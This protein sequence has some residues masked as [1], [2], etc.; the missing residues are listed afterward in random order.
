M[1]KIL[2]K[3][4]LT[5]EERLDLINLTKKGKHS[6]RKVIHALILLNADEGEFAEV[7]KQ[8]NKSIATFLNVGESMVERVK[9]RFVEDSLEAALEDKPSTREY[10]RKID[11]DLEA[12][13]IALSCSEPPEGFVRWSLRM[14]AN[15]AIELQYFDGLSPETIRQ[16][17]KKTK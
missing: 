5:N 2:Y 4:T 12:R 16:T 1:G 14:L 11:G 10:A 3:V 9:R 17:L 8:T 6:S 15:K 13:L 7:S